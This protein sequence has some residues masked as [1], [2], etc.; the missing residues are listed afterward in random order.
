[1]G[2]TQSMS[3]IGNCLDHALMVH[4]NNTIKQWTRKNVAGTYV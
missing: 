4:Y 3:Q 2:L 1:M